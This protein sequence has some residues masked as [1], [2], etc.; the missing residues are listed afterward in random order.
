M[1]A[2][3]HGLLFIKTLNVVIE[4]I[5]LERD[6]A[7]TQVRGVELTREK[8][9]GAIVYKAGSNTKMTDCISSL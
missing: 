1:Y 3:L 6:F 9:R 5:Y 8:V 7:F 2:Y 4:K